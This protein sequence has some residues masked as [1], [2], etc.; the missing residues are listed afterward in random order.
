MSDFEEEKMIEKFKMLTSSTFAVNLKGLKDVNNKHNCKTNMI[1][2]PTR[3]LSLIYSKKNKYVRTSGNL[4]KVF[5]SRNHDQIQF[6]ERSNFHLPK[7]LNLSAGFNDINE[8]IKREKGRVLSVK[9]SLNFNIENKQL[10]SSIDTKNNTF[11]FP[12]SFI[13]ITKEESCEFDEMELNSK[14]KLEFAINSIDEIKTN[15][16]NKNMFFYVS[17]IDI[18]S[19][20]LDLNNYSTNNKSSF[21]SHQV[22]INKKRN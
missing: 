6:I 21:R 2:K 5:R 3:H 8:L 18:N 9:N 11:N 14:E 4:K 15:E 19:K 20:K 12:K 10:I 16:D 22:E 1:S 17:I 7:N 13:D